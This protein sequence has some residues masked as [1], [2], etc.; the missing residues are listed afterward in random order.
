MIAVKDSFS[1]GVHPGSPADAVVVG[2]G[3]AGSVTALLLARQGLHVLLL[4]RQSFPRD[5]PCGEC[6][7]ARATAVLE[8]IGVF[9]AVAAM[10]PARLEGWTVHAPGGFRF[11]GRFQP[12]APALAVERCRLDAALLEAARAEG[13]RFVQVHV[14]GLLWDAQHGDAPARVCGVVGRD[15]QGHP[16]RLR[17][18]LVVGADGLRS[19]VARRMGLVRRPPRLRKASLTTHVDAPGLF[20]P[21]AAWLGEMHLADGACIGLAPVDRSGGRVNLTLVVN[22]RHAPALRSLG[23]ETFMR[24]WIRR[25]PALRERLADGAGLCLEEPFL[26]SGPFDVPTRA[27][28]QRGVALV[29]DAAGYYDPFTGQGIYRALASAELLADVAG[30]ALRL[31]DP[32]APHLASYARRF[33]RLVAGGRRLQH[34]IDW[35]LARPRRADRI[36]RRLARSADVADALVAVTGDARPATALLAPRLLGQFLLATP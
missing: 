30:E 16:V 13:V 27:V 26:A 24:T 36:V 5:K 9:P 33:H 34:V 21:G 20:P 3:P 28:V 8:R 2:A 17:A 35:A 14:T 12:G 32:S 10:A 25:M 11:T 6:L 31:A 23:P 7:S 1:R 22:E 19:V 4:D 18:R 15:T 29:G